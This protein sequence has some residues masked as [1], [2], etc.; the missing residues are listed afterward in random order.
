MKF[1]GETPRIS[2]DSGSFTSNFTH[3]DVRLV[4]LAFKPIKNDF[5]SVRI[6]NARTKL[7]KRL[8]FMAVDL[9][10]SKSQVVHAFRTSRNDKLHEA[11]D[12]KWHNNSTAFGKV[13]DD[14]KAKDIPPNQWARDMMRTRQL[15]GMERNKF[16]SQVAKSWTTACAM[17][18][19]DA[20]SASSGA[21]DGS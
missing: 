14:C 15:A 21:K 8:E 11:I 4:E 2:S 10:V 12:R 16:N 20:D 19:A 6:K 13:L 7:E 1:N 17:G 3:A 5:Q 9:N 18:V